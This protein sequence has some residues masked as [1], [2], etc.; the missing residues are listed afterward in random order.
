V[1]ADSSQGVLNIN[2]RYSDENAGKRTIPTR[3]E[4]KMP[5]FIIGFYSHIRDAIPIV[6][7]ETSGHSFWYA[8]LFRYFL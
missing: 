8:V 7:T 1:V 3:L 5:L 2:I 6:Y 4:S